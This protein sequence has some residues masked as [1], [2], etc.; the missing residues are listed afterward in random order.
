MSKNTQ[1]LSQL[2]STFGPGAMVDL[3]TRSVVVAG[4]EFWDIG[5]EA[6]K[7]VEEP[8]LRVRLER[9][10]RRG[11][12]L[13]DDRSLSLRMPPADVDSLI[14]KPRGVDAPIFPTWF[15]CERVEAG[16][17]S[18]V[19]RRRLVKWGELDGVKR[20][21]Y[22]FEDNRT[23]GVTPI[24][25][26]CACKKGH[27]EDI[28]WRWA[29]H[30]DGAP[31][32]Q[33][34][35]LEERGTSADPSNTSVV[36][37]CGKRMSLAEAFLPRRLGT[38]KANRP[39]L[40]DRDPDGC[41]EELKLLIRTATNTYFPQ[42]ATL[43]SL[44]AQDD[45]LAGLISGIAEDFEEV[46]VFDDLALAKRFHKRIVATLS[47][48]SDAEI[49]DQLQRIRDGQKAEVN[50]SPKVAEFDILASGQAEIGHDEPKAKLYAQTLPRDAWAPPGSQSMLSAIRDV[51]AVHR[52]QEVSC[53]YGFT[54]FE[55]APTS[56]DGDFEDI[57][58][59]VDGAPLSRDA[60]WLPAVEQFGEGL[61]LHFDA[62]AV[63]RWLDQP[64]PKRRNETLAAGYARWAKRLGDKAPDYPGTAYVLLH[65]LSHIL[66]TEIALDCGY[67]ASSLKERIYALATVSGGPVERCG[68]LIYTASPGA[69]GTLGGLVG[70]APRLAGIMACA[71]DRARLCSNDPIC[72]DHEPD[73]R[74]GDRATHGAACHGCLL[75][76]ETSCEN[77]NLLLDRSLLVETLSASGSGFFCT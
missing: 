73:Q 58:L 31:C 19:R 44:P 11:G 15:V 43:I 32:E 21:S 3:P 71:L 17:T 51:V 65:S 50:S 75:I 67:P 27:L 26:V 68:I 70:V 6:F 20:N 9:M 10:L 38:C 54:R 64:D 8:R 34:M 2:V 72:A 25:F 14:D 57:R 33:S 49:F 63:Q 4:L 40:L 12:R 56:T 42:V 76:A 48:W 30:G 7:P 45:A 52:L 5:G 62:V 69:Q 28:P 59:A 74:S 46:H 29:V 41:G 61:F 60:D 18:A 39:W 53:L 37:H 1:R 35:W 22:R 55:A 16:P 66:M 24:R 13:A 77:R 36:C 47:R 23:S